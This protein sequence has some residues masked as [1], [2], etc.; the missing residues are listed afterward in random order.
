MMK[1]QLVKWKK[2][3][4]NNMDESLERE[5]YEHSN[6]IGLCQYHHTRLETDIYGRDYCELCQI[7]DARTQQ[8]IDDRTLGEP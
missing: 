6:S 1:Y 8:E 3:M 7:E 4:M 2:E 5:G